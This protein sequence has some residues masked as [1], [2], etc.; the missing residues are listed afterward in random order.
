M[1]EQTLCTSETVR[2]WALASSLQRA[3]SHKTITRNCLLL[4]CPDYLLRPPVTHICRRVR[5]HSLMQ[6]KRCGWWRNS[7]NIFQFSVQNTSET[8]IFHHGTKSLLTSVT[9]R[10]FVDQCY[11]TYICWPV[12]LYV[13]LLTSVIVR[14]F[15]D[16]CYCTYIC[17]PVLLYVHLLTSVTVR[18]FVDQCY[19]TYICWP[20][21]LYVHLLTSVIWSGNAA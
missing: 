1:V 9:V 4:A 10:A 3:V 19:C 14:T 7:G 8:D 16:Q 15:V 17:W 21:L 18:T 11:C 13:H 5:S 12:L 2:H 20:V 6:R